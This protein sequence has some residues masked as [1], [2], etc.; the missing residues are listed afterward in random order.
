MRVLAIDPGT[1]VSAYVLWNGKILSSDIVDN[2]ELLDVI[3]E[4]EVYPNAVIENVASYGMAVGKEVFA[5]CVWIG[6]FYQ[7][8][9][10]NG[11]NVSLVYRQPVKLHHCKSPKAKDANVRQA[12]IDKYGAPGTKKNPG[13]TYGLKSHLWQAFALAA[14]ATETG[15]CQ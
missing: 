8:L 10:D 13:A 11:V 7:R 14:Y 3:I 5:T 1:D 15:L 6:R 2:S 12:L 4:R 9:S